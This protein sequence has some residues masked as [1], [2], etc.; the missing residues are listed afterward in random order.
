MA[1]ALTLGLGIGA[2]T[3]IFSVV[4]SVLLKP[5]PYGQGPQLV[6]LRQAAPKLNRLNIGFSE[7]EENDYRAQNQTLDD[8]A[9]YH[10]MAFIL[11]G[12][13]PRRVQT[14]VVSYHYFQMMGVRPILGRDFTKED[15]DKGEGEGV[16]LLSNRYW[17]KEFHGDPNI[18][19]RKFQMNNRP[20]TVIG[21]L[22]PLPGYPNDNDV[23]MPVSHCP[24]RSMKMTRE[25]RDH[26]MV[27]LF[28]RMKPGVKEEQALADLATIAGR[29]PG[30]YPAD[31]PKNSNFTMRVAS[32]KEELTH[33][34]K[35][36]FLILLGTA[37]LVLLIACANVANL[38][39]SRVLRRERELGVRAALG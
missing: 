1:A 5:L 35:Q 30:Q 22:P 36:T 33:N 8:I 38:M 18:V 37:G 3:A 4:Y 13:E 11:I 21:V 23:Y 2:N 27:S 17:E 7:K 6:R 20:H 10:S 12:E 19:G 26:R 24:F 34:A 25:A 14:G 9:E 29:F 16:L 15:D 28:A 31:Y 39:L 32:M